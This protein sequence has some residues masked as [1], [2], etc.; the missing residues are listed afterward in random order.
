MKKF[1]TIFITFVGIIAAFSIMYLIKV[2]LITVEK[3]DENLIWMFLIL[4]PVLSILIITLRV[5]KYSDIERVVKITEEE[6]KKLKEIKRKYKNR[7]LNKFTFQLIS[8]VVLL[9]VLSIWLDTVPFLLTIFIFCVA[10]VRSVLK[11]ANDDIWYYNI[12]EFLYLKYNLEECLNKKDKIN[13]LK[14]EISLLKEQLKQ[15]K[16]NRENGK[17]VI[18]T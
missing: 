9:I 17:K 10:L 3:S 16:K 15:R 18:S 6:K 1:E 8:I 7:A 5:M 11:Y 2:G 14:Q 12:D 13:E 4:L